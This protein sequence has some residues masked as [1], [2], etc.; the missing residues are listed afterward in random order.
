VVGL[1]GVDGLLAALIDAGAIMSMVP[2]LKILRI[3]KTYALSPA[4]QQ[5]RQD[6]ISLSNG[7]YFIQFNSTYIHTKE[8]YYS[9]TV[10]TVETNKRTNATNNEGGI[11]T[12]STSKMPSSICTS[13][14]I[15]VETATAVVIN[16]T[17]ENDHH[18]SANVNTEQAS[19]DGTAMTMETESVP[20]EL[21]LHQVDLS[22]PRMDPVRINTAY[23]IVHQLGSVG[24]LN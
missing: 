23:S 13:V 6:M 11:A 8:G 18:D 22:D 5:R 21:Q 20:L 10:G 2:A 14:V 3:E 24:K 16:D 1:V 17:E 12:A 9:T 15:D 7:M 4:H 19:G